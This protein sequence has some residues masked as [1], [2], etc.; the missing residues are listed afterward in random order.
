MA[1]SAH[2]LPRLARQTQRHHNIHR[3]PSS[4]HKDNDNHYLLIRSK[5]PA[6]RLDRVSDTHLKHA[7]DNARG[8]FAERGRRP[9]CV[10]LAGEWLVEGCEVSVGGFDV[11]GGGRG[12][13][14]GC[15]GAEVAFYACGAECVY[16]GKGR[17]GEGAAG[18]G[19]G[20]FDEGDGK[21]D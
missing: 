10:D 5:T 2:H 16:E 9:Q 18:G 14:L 20:G 11:G 6:R 21:G 19:E 4:I 12:G 17:I 3:T 1:P 15:G 8:R 7:A 13:V